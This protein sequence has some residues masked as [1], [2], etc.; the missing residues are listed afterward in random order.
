MRRD[1]GEV[2]EGKCPSRARSVHQARGPQDV[3]VLWPSCMV[4]TSRSG[5][6]LILSRFTDVTQAAHAPIGEVVTSSPTASLHHH[7]VSS[8]QRLWSVI[9]WH[10]VT[11]CNI[12]S[13]PRGSPTRA[14]HASLI[15]KTSK[16]RLMRGRRMSRQRATPLLFITCTCE[17]STSRE[18]NIL[19][20]HKITLGL[21]WFLNPDHVLFLVGQEK[22][23]FEEEGI[24]L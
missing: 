11:S 15:H 13:R 7:R 12:T 19:M 21:E 14:S 2:R 24:E 3:N 17:S 16:W 5:R 6:T 22:G 4:R 23:W 9:S 18:R 10:T 20:A 8:R 1:D